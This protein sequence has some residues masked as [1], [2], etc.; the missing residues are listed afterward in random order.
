MTPT[1]KITKKV[2][3]WQFYWP[4][5][6][7]GLLIIICILAGINFMQQGKTGWGWTFFVI[8]GILIVIL[9]KMLASGKRTSG[10]GGG[11]SFGGGAGGSW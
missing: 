6:L 8:A 1:S 2:S 9:L 7:I 3:W 4:H 5:M 11:S 10:F